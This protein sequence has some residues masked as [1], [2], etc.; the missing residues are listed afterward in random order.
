MVKAIQGRGIL[1]CTTLK[2]YLL[3]YDHTIGGCVAAMLL[4]TPYRGLTFTVMLCKGTA[5]LLVIRTVSRFL[6]RTLFTSAHAPQTWYHGSS[7]AC[8]ALS[9]AKDD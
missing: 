2:K 9:N 3:D 8:F 6:F 7:S 1:S 4:V 5:V